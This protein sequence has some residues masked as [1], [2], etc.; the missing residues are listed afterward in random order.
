MSAQLSPLTELSG[1]AAIV[2][3]L[4]REVLGSILGRD[5]YPDARL[6][7]YPH[8]FQEISDIEPQIRSRS[9]PPKMIYNSS[10]FSPTIRR[11]TV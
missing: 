10:F 8:S 5:T 9:P 2:W 6:S 4:I 1:V 7:G 3:T 11:Y